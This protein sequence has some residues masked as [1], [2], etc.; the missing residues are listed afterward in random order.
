MTTE[1]LCV[2]SWDVWQ[3]Y[4]KDRGSPP[5]IKVHRNLMSNPEW[6]ILSDAEK[7]QLVSIWLLA[8]DKGGTIPSS[9]ALLRK[10]CLLDDAPDVNRFKDLGFLETKRLPCG[11]HVVTTTGQSDAPEV[12]TE[13]ETEVDITPPAQPKKP[14]APKKKKVDPEFEKIWE[15]RP[16]RLGSNPKNRALSAWKA[17]MAEKHNPEEISAGLVRYNSFLTAKGSVGTEFVMQMSTFL[18]PGLHFKETWVEAGVSTEYLD[19]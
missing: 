13:V 5:W 10:M 4:R 15:L 11:N 1:C 7:G 2:T 12:E 14:P 8:A 18:G 19:L 9:P 6:A 16:A 3:T 17:R